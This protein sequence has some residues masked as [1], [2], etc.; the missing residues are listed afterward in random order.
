MTDIE[1][2]RKELETAKRIRDDGKCLYID[3]DECPFRCP[4]VAPTCLDAKSTGIVNDLISAREAELAETEKGQ[5]G[6][7]GDGESG[8]QDGLLH[9]QTAPEAGK[10]LRDAMPELFRA[11]DR[12]PTLDDFALALIQGMGQDAIIHHPET[13]YDL[14]AAYKA[15]SDRR[16]V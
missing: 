10:T 4:L 7:Y 16:R 5:E 14:A 11:T 12:P 13:L 3:C 2:K 6:I 8:P 15:E 1:I 9:V